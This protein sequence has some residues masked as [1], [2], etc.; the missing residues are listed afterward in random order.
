MRK[1]RAAVLAGTVLAGLGMI[2]GCNSRNSRYQYIGGLYQNFKADYNDPNFMF[3]ESALRS[4]IDNGADGYRIKQY[5][6]DISH[7]GSPQKAFDM[8][9]IAS[10]LPNVPMPTDVEFEE[11]ARA[12]FKESRGID[13]SA[14]SPEGRQ[15]MLF[16][17]DMDARFFDPSNPVGITL[18]AIRYVGSSLGPSDRERH[19]ARW[20]A[21]QHNS[22]FL[23]AYKNARG[24]YPI[25]NEEINQA[26]QN[27][28]SQEQLRPIKT[29]NYTSTV[30]SSPTATTESRNIVI[31]E[32]ESEA[33]SRY[34][35]EQTQQRT[36]SIGQQR[37]DSYQR[38]GEDLNRAVEVAR[39]RGGQIITQGANG[40]ID[41]GRGI[42]GEIQKAQEQKK[43]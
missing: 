19:V 30:R 28:I 33:R 3:Q 40:V 41:A 35:R 5:L 34:M 7:D 23:D 38:A 11:Y 31:G 8:L 13:I 32:T 10:G 36:Q 12:Y 29:P 2:A 14:L 39:Q 6:N 26:R 27:V 24:H 9:F 37:H 18:L 20:A 25:T 43:R 4:L 42:L 1:I 16:S 15:R 17:H 21:A 22:G